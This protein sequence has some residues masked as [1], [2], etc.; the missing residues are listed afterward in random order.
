MAIINL[1]PSSKKSFKAAAAPK[2]E[3]L[4]AG[5]KISGKMIFI[6]AGIAFL[7]CVCWAFLFI[8]LRTRK[9]QLSFLE[10][11]LADLDYSN[12]Q[13]Q[14]LNKRVNEMNNRLNFYKKAS[15]NEFSWAKLLGFINEAAPMQVWFTNI[16]TEANP[17][18]ILIISGSAA[19]TAQSKEIDSLSYFTQRLKNFTYFSKN[20]EEIKLGPISVEKKGN[21]NVITFTVFCRFKT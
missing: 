9:S 10:K 3:N 13:I 19:S 12:K 6:P 15:G 7:I 14:S 2:L 17:N 5:F 16:H 21:V 18:K 11:Q 20:F 1:L 4:K 8:Q